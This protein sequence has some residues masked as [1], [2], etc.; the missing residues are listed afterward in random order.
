[1]TNEK[2]WLPK[3]SNTFLHNHKGVH[4]LEQRVSKF[5]ID[6]GRF[7][8]FLVIS[9]GK[10]LLIWRTKFVVI[11]CERIQWSQ[12]IPSRTKLSGAVARVATN[13]SSW[14]LSSPQL[15]VQ[16]IS[17]WG[18][19]RLPRSSIFTSPVERIFIRSKSGATRHDEGENRIFLH[20]SES[21]CTLHDPI[22]IMD[23]SLY[24]TII[25]CWVERDS[26]WFYV[27]SSRIIGNIFTEVEIRGLFLRWALSVT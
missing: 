20:E 1:M 27:V 23:V 14:H 26:V 21:C 2:Y 7:Y 25:M 5:E 15:I 17:D 22:V 8:N 10:W 12:L 19:E 4:L 3:C 13:V 11:S 9:K 6:W 24:K 18:F 16:N